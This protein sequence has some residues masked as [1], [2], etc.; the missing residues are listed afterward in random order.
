MS[1]TRLPSFFLLAAAFSVVGGFCTVTPALAD[2]ASY[3]PSPNA[4]VCRLMPVPDIERAL[5]VKKT[6]VSG[7]DNP[8]LSICTAEFGTTVVAKLQYAKQ[9]GAGLPTDVRTM[10]AI[11]HQMQSEGEK[12][13]IQDF[14]NV[15]CFGQQVKVPGSSVWASTC[16]NPRGFITLS[17]ARP[18]AMVPFDTVR[19][20]LA[21]AQAKI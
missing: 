15:G 18:A 16:G 13:T 4:K 17:V 7:T 11:P 20:L 14:G 10:L 12:V 9:G 2:S 19:K 5:A 3:L 8:N 21:A 1:L 6:K